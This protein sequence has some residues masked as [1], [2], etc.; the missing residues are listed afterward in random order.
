MGFQYEFGKF[1]DLFY[2]INFWVVILMGSKIILVGDVLCGNIV[3]IGG[4][5]KFFVKLGI[6]IIFEKVYN[7]KVDIRIF[8]YNNNIMFF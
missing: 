5:D 3:G 4:I 6:V 7:M 2:K 1:Y 8:Y